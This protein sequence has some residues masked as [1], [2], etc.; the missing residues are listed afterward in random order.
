MSARTKDIN[1]S[2]GEQSKRISA[3]ERTVSENKKETDNTISRIE[4]MST[5]RTPKTWRQS[6][7]A[8]RTTKKT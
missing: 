6:R 2:I 4:N 1:D 3:V 7:A 8:R 5:P